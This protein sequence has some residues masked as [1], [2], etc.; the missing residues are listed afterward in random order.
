MSSVPM[1]ASCAKRLFQVRRLSCGQ[2]RACSLAAGI[3]KSEA[4]RLGLTAHAIAHSIDF[5]MT[6]WQMPAVHSSEPFDVGVVVSFGHFIPKRVIESFP[7]GMVNV[8]PSLLP[9]WAP[10]L[11]RPD[12]VSRRDVGED[13]EERRR[14]RSP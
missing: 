11:L 1:I 7:L 9:K 10:A 14:F 4:E 5:R 3:V 13:T 6:N 12:V 8:H 2:K